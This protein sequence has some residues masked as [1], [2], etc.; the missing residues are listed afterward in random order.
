MLP[1]IFGL[2]P[3]FTRKIDSVF[4]DWLYKGRA[5]LQRGP[6]RSS[7]APAAQMGPAQRRPYRSQHERKITM[8]WLAISRSAA[9]AATTAAA[10]SLAIS[11]R[12]HRS[13]PED[14]H[15]EYRI[16]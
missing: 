5:A 9:A 3:Q 7:F 6:W 12:T 13:P 1:G 16:V 10:K 2:P 11:A 14:P 8:I 4:P 15:D